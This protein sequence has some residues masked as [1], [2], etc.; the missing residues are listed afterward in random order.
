MAYVGLV[1]VIVLLIN[2]YADNKYYKKENEELKKKIR[3][4]KG[5][6]ITEIKEKVAPTQ[7]NIYIEEK[8]E[9]IESVK[10][11]KIEEPVIKEEKKAQVNTE[12]IIL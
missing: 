9:K 8:V 7:S 5:Q 2:V 1:I 10:E 12:G 3:E 11:E 4:L 6:D